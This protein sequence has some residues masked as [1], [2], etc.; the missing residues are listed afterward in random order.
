MSDVNLTCTTEERESILMHSLAFNFVL[1]DYL[2]NK[3]VTTDIGIVRIK[4][5]VILDYGVV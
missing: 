5:T 4:A 1:S 2:K 3:D